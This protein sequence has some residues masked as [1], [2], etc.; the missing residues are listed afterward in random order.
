MSAESYEIEIWEEAA[1]DSF[2]QIGR[3]EVFDLLTKGEK[4]KLGDH[5]ACWAN[6]L[7]ESR[8]HN[9]GLGGKSYQQTEI[10]RLEKAL[11][12]E[13]SKIV[14]TVCGGAGRERYSA[15][16]WAVDTQCSRC[17]GDGRVLP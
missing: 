15:G 9:H 4:N 12:Q 8:S 10:E 3:S 1:G 7:N 11:R 5:L 16:V 14:C 2:D 17:N 13:R 6:S